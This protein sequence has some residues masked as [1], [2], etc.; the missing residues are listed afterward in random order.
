MSLFFQ[1]EK[2]ASDKFPR[3][4]TNIKNINYMADASACVKL[5]IVNSGSVNATI[6]GKSYTAQAGDILLILP[7]EIHSFAS[8]SSDVAI[9]NIPC[10]GDNDDTDIN[11]CVSGNPVIKGSSVLSRELRDYIGIITKELSNK[12][13]GYS[14]MA[15]GIAGVLVSSLIN[16][17]AVR[18][19]TPD[20]LKKQEAESTLL[21]TVKEYIRESYRENISLE[22]T[23]AHC[24]LSLFYFS[25]L[26][27][28]ITGV[29]FYDYLTSYRLDKA[30]DM[31]LE[32][33]KILN[34][35]SECGFATVRT[36]NR[37]FKSFFGCSPSE[38]L[39]SNR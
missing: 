33:K 14:Y 7:G 31:L 22:S 12:G 11:K 37:S 19:L 30:L 36:F 25:H 13:P 28:R 29:T 3:L 27:K 35:A 26:F 39:S 18:E 24:N 23:S 21:M 17:R 38:Y 2:C 16:S 32:N 5:V 34:V 20:E 6:N 10:N 8:D 1:S 4:N 15:K 9:L